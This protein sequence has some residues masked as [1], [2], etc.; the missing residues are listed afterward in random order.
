MGKYHI[1]CS[2]WQGKKLSFLCFLNEFKL[3]YSLLRKVENWNNSRKI[4]HKISR[5]FLLQC[6]LECLCS[7][8]YFYFIYHYFIHYYFIFVIISIKCCY[9]CFVCLLLQNLMLL[10]C[11]GVFFCSTVS[12]STSLYFVIV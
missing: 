2:K 8:F 9:G 10:F 12:F 1:D 11:Y 5:L 4:G 7:L 6:E 3:Y